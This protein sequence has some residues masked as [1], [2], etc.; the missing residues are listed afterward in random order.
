[1]GIF[2]VNTPV[3]ADLNLLIQI[4]IFIILIFGWYLKSKRRY[5]K[6]G[7]IMGIG[8]VFHTIS[9]FAV[10]VPSL[11][12]MKGIF[13]NPFSPITLVTIAHS[14]LGSLV[15]ILGIWL[16]GRWALNTKK[17]DVCL[18]KKNIMR[19]VASL[20][21]LELLLGLCTYFLLYII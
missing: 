4:A 15:E 19:V 8:L 7:V 11:L 17:I 16:V 13:E 18:K 9:I 2:I 6:H 5:V 10:M 1:M 14:V 21:I 12:S 3:L 20:W